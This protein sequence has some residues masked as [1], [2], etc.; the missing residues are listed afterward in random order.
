MERSLKFAPVIAGSVALLSIVI[1]ASTAFLSPLISPRRN[2]KD[3]DYEG[4]KLYEDEDGIATERSQQEY[5]ATF[6]RY[7]LLASSAMGALITIAGSIF[8]TVH[9]NNG[10]FVEC[11]IEFGSWVDGER[12]V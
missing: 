1:V 2:S 6:P 7:L 11:W 3:S 9:P 8:T 12:G 10:L 5:S 4:H